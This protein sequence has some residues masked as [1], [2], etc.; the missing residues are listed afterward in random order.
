[1]SVI[2]LRLTDT[3][4]DFIF[5]L[6]GNKDLVCEKQMVD[7]NTCIYLKYLICVVEHVSYC[8]RKTYLHLT[9]SQVAKPT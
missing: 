8:N 2:R 6:P 1:M 7:R 9:Q 4:T 5:L 3:S